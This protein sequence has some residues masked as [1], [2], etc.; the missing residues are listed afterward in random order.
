MKYKFLEVR[1]PISLNAASR[2][3]GGSQGVRYAAPDQGNYT[4]CKGAGNLFR[5]TLYLNEVFSVFDHLVA[6]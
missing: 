5:Y 2:S 6:K 4:P 1:L 3:F